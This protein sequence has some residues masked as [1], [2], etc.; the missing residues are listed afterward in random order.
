MQ[1]KKVLIS[2]GLVG[3]VT[4]LSLLLGTGA[5]KPVKFDGSTPITLNMKEKYNAKKTPPGFD[6]KK[7]IETGKKIGIN[8]E[9]AQKSGI[10]DATTFSQKLG[11]AISNDTITVN[12]EL[13]KD[14]DYFVGSGGSIELNI[15]GKKHTLAILSSLV[16]H[17]KLKNGNNLMT[18]SFESEMKDTNGNLVPSTVSFIS[19]NETGERFFYV[20]MGTV[21]EGPV[22]LSFGDDSFGTQEIRDIVRGQSNIEEDSH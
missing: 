22:V 5:S 1:K 15:E 10:S 9:A 17:F 3:I 12:Q 19:I 21:E 7:N 11:S 14:G 2:A 13:R 4:S 6:K 8:V 16:S 20:V 18:G